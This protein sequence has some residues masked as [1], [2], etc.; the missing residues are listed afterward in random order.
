MGNKVIYVDFSKKHKKNQNKTTSKKKQGFNK[1]GSLK[2]ILLA[3][4]YFFR[5]IKIKHFNKRN[6]KKNN[7][8]NIM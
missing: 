6:S 8:T 3:I 2:N 7:S 5:N 1:F 4:K